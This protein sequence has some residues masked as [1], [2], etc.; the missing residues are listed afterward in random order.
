MQTVYFW[1]LVDRFELLNYSLPPTLVE[2]L[3]FLCQMVYKLL[4][5]DDNPSQDPR[6]ILDY[7][8]TAETTDSVQLM[9]I[10]K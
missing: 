1:K 4:C 9:E 2:F 6:E 7:L 3:L 8:A 5:N 10:G